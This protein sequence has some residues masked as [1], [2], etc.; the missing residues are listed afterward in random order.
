MKEKKGVIRCWVQ[1]ALSLVSGFSGTD[2]DGPL[3]KSSVLSLS[4]FSTTV[5]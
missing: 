4:V 2:T 3:C 5:S 1:A